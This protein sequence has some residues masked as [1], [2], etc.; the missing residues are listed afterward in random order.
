MVWWLLFLRANFSSKFQKRFSTSS[1]S[2]VPQKLLCSSSRHRSLHQ[3]SPRSELQPGVYRDSSLGALRPGV[4]AV[5]FICYFHICLL[6]VFKRFSL[7]SRTDFCCCITNYDKFS[8]LSNKHLSFHFLRKES[9][10]RVFSSG[11]QDWSENVTG[12]QSHQELKSSSELIFWEFTS[13][14][15]QLKPSA[16]RIAQTFPDRWLSPKHGSLLYS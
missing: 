12:V 2:A 8:I 13:T 9:K 11:S 5:P 4:M 15:E 3:P 6:F 16:T 1:A 14:V 10:H 7:L